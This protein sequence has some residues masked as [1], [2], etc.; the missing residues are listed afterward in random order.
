MQNCAII[1]MFRKDFRT[2]DGNVKGTYNKAI[3]WT[4]IRIPKGIWIISKEAGCDGFGPSTDR[5]IISV[6]AGRAIF[7]YIRQEVG[8]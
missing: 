8:S 6:G 5:V 3:N 2:I 7:L 4:S 1:R